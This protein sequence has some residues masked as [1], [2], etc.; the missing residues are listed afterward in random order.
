MNW[1]MATDRV[2]F[3]L[4]VDAS[5]LGSYAIPILEYSLRVPSTLFFQRGSAYGRNVAL[6]SGATVNHVDQAA[7][8]FYGFLQAGGL[9]RRQC[10]ALGRWRGLY[11]RQ[12]RRG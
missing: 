9:S 5:G 3:L 6:C 7:S 10:P 4:E 12:C 8:I 11:D 1:A 2:L